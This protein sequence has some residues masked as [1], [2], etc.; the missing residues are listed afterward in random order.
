MNDVELLQ[1]LS[2]AGRGASPW[3]AYNIRPAPGD[4]VEDPRGMAFEV[5]DPGKNGH[6]EHW[7]DGAGMAAGALLHV[8]LWARA[9]GHERLGINV[10]LY[11]HPT[12]DAG[13][14]VHQ[15]H[16]P[17]DGAWHRLERAIPLPPKPVR[18]IRI[19]I[20]ARVGAGPFSLDGVSLRYGATGKTDWEKDLL[21]NH[22]SAAYHDA[23][24]ALVSRHPSAGDPA[25][26][27]KL[28]RYLLG[29]NRNGMKNVAAVEMLLSERGLRLAGSR[30]LDLG[31]GA[32]GSLV[33]A[34]KGGA[35][36]AEGWEINGEKRALAA[37]N[38]ATC[39][40]DTLRVTVRD[41]SMEVPEVLGPDFEAFH[42]VF[43]EEVLEHVK[44]LDAAIATLARCIKP[45]G[46]GYITM[47][48]G[49]AFQSVLADP[50]LQ[51]FGIALLDRFEAQP[52][53]TALKNHTHYSD[54]IGAYHRHGDYVA[55]FAA[56]GL[57]LTPVE[58]PPAG[59][60]AM[61]R[62][63]R[64]LDAIAARRATL[65]ADW[66][67]VVDG[68]TLTLLEDRL[69]AYLSDARERYAAARKVGAGTEAQEA[70]A[71]DYGQAHFAYIAEHAATGG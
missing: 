53:A 21:A 36:W 25:F 66:G 62:I 2:A 69:D 65:R 49:Y 30:F 64:N 31:S 19:L 35:A 55:R 18:R 63:S 68:N 10:Y 45:G 15:L 54:M 61:D 43:C 13:R 38:V 24:L 23:V 28:S 41:Q 29:T 14:T 56:A 8:D 60:R 4:G 70:F 48:N 59:S 27:D 52:L 11:P 50:H 9:Q 7:C 71:R 37:V 40:V 42:I 1:P 44:D 67:D 32:G 34:L 17:G 5:P 57:R 22:I 6:L 16:H 26:R 47:P 12:T 46:A 20:V 33:A 39:G 58:Q 51:L 3:K